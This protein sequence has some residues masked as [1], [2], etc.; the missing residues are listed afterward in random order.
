MN[1]IDKGFQYAIEKKVGAGAFGEVYK[2]FLKKEP[3][4]LVAL[5]F[6]VELSPKVKS[7]GGNHMILPPFGPFSISG[8][9][10]NSGVDFQAKFSNENMYFLTLPP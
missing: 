5:K 1:N 8:K 9:L 2:G 4:K 6:A 3:T 10:L 7:Y